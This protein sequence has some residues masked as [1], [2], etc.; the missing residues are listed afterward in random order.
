M[1]PA[2]LAL[3]EAL[4]H[5]PASLMSLEELVEAFTSPEQTISPTMQSPA[6]LDS[7][8]APVQV[9]EVTLISPLLC[10]SRASM[11]QAMVPTLISPLL[12]VVMLRSPHWTDE[13]S[14]S[15]LLDAFRVTGF[16]VFKPF[17]KV[18]SEALEVENEVTFV[19]RVNLGIR[20]ARSLGI[21]YID[22]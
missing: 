15:P 19:G 2:E 20:R 17:A 5:V 1:L 3:N 12:E 22:R 13:A 6:E 18:M 14:M 9:A 11:P 10:V 8:S 4:R 7:I 21:D 16:E